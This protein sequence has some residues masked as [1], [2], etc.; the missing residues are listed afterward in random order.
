M[1]WSFY[2]K[3]WINILCINHHSP[4]MCL[5]STFYSISLLVSCGCLC[6]VR[7]P[8]PV[9]DGW[10]FGLFRKSDENML[11]KVCKEENWNRLEEVGNRVSFLCLY[12][13]WKQQLQHS[14]WPETVGKG[15]RQPWDPCL[16]SACLWT[17]LTPHLSGFC[18]LLGWTGCPSLCI[19]A[20]QGFFPSFKVFT[21][22][23]F[24]F[25]LYKSQTEDENRNFHF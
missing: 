4:S 6:A 23:F 3:R 15:L 17:H 25:L 7:R 19:K 12:F 14:G 21:L 8:S 11:I 1:Y 13:H 18:F 5:P 20:T 22:F 9:V 2:V 16:L 24:K 10:V